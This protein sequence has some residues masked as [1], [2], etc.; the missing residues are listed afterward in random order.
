[1]LLIGRNRGGG[2]AVTAS[3]QILGSLSVD[4]FGII[5]IDGLFAKSC[6]LVN[7]LGPSNA[8]C[9]YITS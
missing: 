4:D 5:G 7:V 8:I 1:M 9:A 6:T 2:D 3:D